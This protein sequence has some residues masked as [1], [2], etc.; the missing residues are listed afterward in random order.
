MW[1]Y[2]TQ[3]LT[4]MHFFGGQW[5]DFQQLSRGSETLHITSEGVGRDIWSHLSSQMH[6][7]IVQSKA[8]ALRLGNAQWALREERSGPS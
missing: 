3:N 7:A 1:P 2:V 6:Q 4:N 5:V 8:H